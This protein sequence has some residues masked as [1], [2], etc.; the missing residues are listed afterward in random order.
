MTLSALPMVR[1]PYPKTWFEWR[2]RLE[3]RQPPVSGKPVPQRL[4]CL[5]E[6]DNKTLDRGTYT[7]DPP[8]V[9]TKRRAAIIARWAARSPRSSRHAVDIE[10]EDLTRLNK[11]RLGKRADASGPARL[12][13]L[14]NYCSCRVLPIMRVVS[15]DTS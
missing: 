9:S 13:H 10:R 12:L 7:F 2:D 8:Q 15:A 3:P 11:R 4:G 6:A 14:E 5:V 1:A